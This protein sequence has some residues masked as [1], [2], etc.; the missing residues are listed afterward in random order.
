MWNLFR[1]KA[2]QYHSARHTLFRCVVS[3]LARGVRVGSSRIVGNHRVTPCASYSGRCFVGNLSVLV[4]GQCTLRLSIGLVGIAMRCAGLRRPR[5]GLRK[6]YLDET[7]V[8]ALLAEALTA[9]VE[10]VLADQTHGV[11]ADAAV[12]FL[13]ALH[14]RISHCPFRHGWRSVPFHISIQ[15]L[16][17]ENNVP[18]AG[19]LAVGPRTRIPDRLVRHVGWLCEGLTVSLLVDV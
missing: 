2:M 17:Y 6:S 7:N 18:L 9:D 3:M 5:G 1:K 15:C 4:E 13:S 10:A 11:S 19:A 16:R 12:R 14:C 8:G